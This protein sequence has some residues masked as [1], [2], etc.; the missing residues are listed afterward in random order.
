MNLLTEDEVKE[1]ILYQKIIEQ[2][3]REASRS[4]KRLLLESRQRKERACPFVV[5]RHLK[6]KS[7]KQTRKCTWDEYHVQ[8]IH[9]RNVRLS[10]EPGWDSCFEPNEV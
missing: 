5:F 1:Q 2:K 6:P 3:E 8:N 9:M 10:I 7:A 4:A